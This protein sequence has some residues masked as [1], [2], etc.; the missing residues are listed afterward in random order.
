MNTAKQWYCFYTG[1]FGAPTAPAGVCPSAVTIIRLTVSMR[2]TGCC[3]SKEG[4]RQGD[5][6]QGGPQEAGGT[7]TA[8]LNLL[9]CSAAAVMVAGNRAHAVK[10][11]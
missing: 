6:S 8:A 11:D 4:G 9:V 10:H 3:Q 2:R 5:E 7:L 1:S